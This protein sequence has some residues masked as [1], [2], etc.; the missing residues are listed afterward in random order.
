M[1]KTELCVSSI[2]LW[3]KNNTVK[4]NYVK[5]HILS[6]HQD[7]HPN[8]VKMRQRVSVTNLT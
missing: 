1:K 7:A 8:S 3:M 2:G 6:I 4:L 5:S